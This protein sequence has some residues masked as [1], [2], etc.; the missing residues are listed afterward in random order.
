MCIPLHPFLYSKNGIYMGKHYFCSKTSIVG[1]CENRLTE[2]ILT[3]THNLCFEQKYENS[4]KKK[5]TENCHFYSREISL[6][7]ACVCL[8]NGL[9]CLPM[10]PYFLCQTL[11]EPR[12]EKTGLWGFR[13]GQ[14]QTR[15][16]SHRRWLES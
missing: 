5:S 2:A 16:Y 10:P 15:L 7:I 12:S 3:C 6:Y 13:P 4:K 11:Y 1:T 8:R 14:T 9:H